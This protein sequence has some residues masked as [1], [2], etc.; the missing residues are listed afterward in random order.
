M[1]KIEY[2]KSLKKVKL[3]LGNGFDLHCKL[4]SSYSDYIFKNNQTF[5]YLKTIISEYK[6]QFN[7]CIPYYENTTF[8]QIEI[9][10]INIFDFIFALL[11]LSNIKNVA[12]F[13]V[14]EIIQRSLQDNPMHS[15]V[16]FPFVL[17]TIQEKKSDSYFNCDILASLIINKANLSSIYHEE[18]FYSFLL[19]ELKQFEK[20]FGHFI[21]NQRENIDNH[22]FS[23]GLKNSRFE[24]CSQYT[25][26]F[27]C[28]ETEVVSVDN[29]NYDDCGFG[30]FSSKER[31]INGNTEA[32]IFGIDSIFPP[33]DCRIIFTKTY[34]RMMEDM[35]N[36]IVKPP[37]IFENVVIY[38]HSL[39]KA[40]YSY[41]FPIF[42]QLQLTNSLAKG[43][44][45]FAFT[46]FDQL[47][48]SQIK[49]SLNKSIYEIIESYAAYKN[50]LNKEK[51]RLVDYLSIQKR[52]V[53]YEIPEITNRELTYKN[54]FD[55]GFEAK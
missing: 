9:N 3:I 15:Q 21:K 8:K 51:I 43:S 29:F 42:D 49:A 12:W 25:I 18:Q 14:E 1:D 19:S 46:I 2:I 13:N 39:D 23:I 26:S 37:K 54:H 22:C 52:I 33:N 32:P 35:D 48:E 5:T 10:Q 53:L 47:N 6:K 36:Q 7:D 11:S 4:H 41:F 34:R 24:K 30:A 27:L 16:S 31:N 50:Y 55:S 28:E 45:V 44:I 38:G 40:D 17:K 20:K